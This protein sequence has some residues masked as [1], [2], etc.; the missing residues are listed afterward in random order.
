MFNGHGHFI[1]GGDLTIAE[2][3]GNFLTRGWGRLEPGEF[4]TPAVRPVGMPANLAVNNV[5][6]S[7]YNA[8]GL[9]PSGPLK[10][11]AFGDNG[12]TSQFQYGTIVG[13]TEMQGGNDY[14]STLNPDEDMVAAYD[15]GAV[16][17]R[18]EYDFDNA[19]VQSAYASFNYGHLNTFGDSFGAQ[20]PNFNSYPVLNTNPFLPASVVAA[21]AAN[22]ITSFAYS[23]TSD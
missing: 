11:I 18:F 15:R 3:T 4:S 13:S 10:G 12:T 1:I 7:A 21:M 14:G 8:S 5:S 2:G 17:T 20:V 6:T 9:I 23:A 22:K 16:L 19:I